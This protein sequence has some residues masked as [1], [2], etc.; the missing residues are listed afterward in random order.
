MN[1]YIVFTY[2][3]DILLSKLLGATIKKDIIVH[4]PNND[5]NEDVSYFVEYKIGEFVY[6]IYDH[7]T[8]SHSTLIRLNMAKRALNMEY[9]DSLVREYD[10]KLPKERAEEILRDYSEYISKERYSVV[11]GSIF[12][13]SSCKSNSHFIKDTI[14]MIKDIDGNLDPYKVPYILEFEDDTSAT[15]WAEVMKE[16]YAAVMNEQY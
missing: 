1:K 16:D 2:Y 6:K 14:G 9:D 5:G 11:D 10:D 13:N 8:S 3:G 4:S 7:Y 12:Y 15:L